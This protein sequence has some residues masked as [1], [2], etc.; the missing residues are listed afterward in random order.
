MSSFEAPHLAPPPTTKGQATRERI[1]RAAAQLMFEQGAAGTSTPA[2]RDAAGVSSSQIYHYFANKQALTRAV[3]EYQTEAV[4][5]GQE[6]LLARLDSVEALRAWRDMVVGV[7]RSMHWSGGCPLGS[8]ASELAEHDADARTALA[9]SFSRWSDAIRDG[10][11]RM[12]ERG[13]LRPEADPDS[14]ALALLAA[15]Q[16]GL[17]L[18]QAQRS[19]A[20]LEAGLDAIIT[21]IAQHVADRRP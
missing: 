1:V 8:L 10:L 15:L 12:A 19:S 17:L 5:G 16:G 6:Q 21:L 4:V 2:V 7:Q 18:G 9:A 3:I 14:L 20:A 11:A 13:A